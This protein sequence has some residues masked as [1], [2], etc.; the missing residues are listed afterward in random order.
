M[1]VVA[2]YAA[3]VLH[4]LHVLSRV[5][6]ALYIYGVKKLGWMYVTDRGTLLRRQGTVVPPRSAG[7]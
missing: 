4:V 2:G 7:V 1:V 5:S 3:V 6:L